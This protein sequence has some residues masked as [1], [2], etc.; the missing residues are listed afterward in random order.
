M[1]PWRDHR[2]RG[3]GGDLWPARRMS[4][5]RIGHLRA[6]GDPIPDADRT[7]GRDRRGGRSWC[8]QEDSRVGTGTAAVVEPGRGPGPRIDLPAMPREEAGGSLRLGEC[9]RR[10]IDAVA[11][12]RPAVGPDRS[13]LEEI[14]IPAPGRSWMRGDPRLST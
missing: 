4:R 1:D 2:R 12:G 8:D 6:R 11:L 3:P 5:A 7:C 9:A 10:S 14:P 13:A